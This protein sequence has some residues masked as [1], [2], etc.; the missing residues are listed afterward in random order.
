MYTLKNVI[1][2]AVSS[3]KG[4][5]GKTTVSI[6]LAYAFAR[7]GR[8]VL[9]VDADP[10]G[11]VGLS[12]TRQTKSLKGFFDYLSNGEEESLQSIVVPTRMETL[13]LI[14]AGQGG[15]YDMS[16]GFQG[17]AEDK[18]K[19]FICAAEAV[20][21]D[22]CIIDTAAGLFGV[23]KDVLVCSD[24]VLV[25]QQSEP[26]GVRSMPKMLEALRSVRVKN[27]NLFILGVVL[28]MVQREL[29]ES[30]EAG[31]GLRAI[32]PSNLVLNAEVPRDDVFIKASARGIPV[33]V[34][35]EGR[36]VLV[37]FDSLRKEIE[38]KLARVYQ[39]SPQIN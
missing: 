29:E 35:Q 38:V 33:G 12:L 27:P 37:E 26:L 18:V 31:A 21:Y 14:P 19:N 17:G 8:C 16:M 20:G 13:S 4:G 25:P 39:S 30:L 11:S 28:T 2:I 32:L 24:A 22:L 7:S 5:V 36:E 15:D 9:L 1:T 3:Q 10:Q 23:T 6:N 34:M